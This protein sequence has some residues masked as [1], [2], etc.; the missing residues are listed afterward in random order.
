MITREQLEKKP[1]YP[2][3][4]YE[5]EIQ[6]VEHIAGVGSNGEP[7]QQAKIKTDRRDVYS[8]T[9]AVY[10][11]FVKQPGPKDGRFSQMINAL[12]NTQEFRRAQG[13]SG[14]DYQSLI[15]LL[16]LISTYANTSAGYGDEISQGEL[17]SN[18]AA[19]EKQ[20]DP[21]LNI[22]KEIWKY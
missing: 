15:P 20:F 16:Q 7:Y 1:A 19:W 3:G 17:E 10:E 9:G 12:P 14:G 18:F 11:K 21:D 2:V 22:G 6:L 13:A 8:I 5:L 4:E